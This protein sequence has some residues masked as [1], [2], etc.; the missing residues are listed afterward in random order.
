MRLWSNEIET[1]EIRST[2]TETRHETSHKLFYLRQGCELKVESRNRMF[3][4][5][6]EVV[7]LIC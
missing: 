6:V 2:E 5:G 1:D 4:D 3:L 7:F